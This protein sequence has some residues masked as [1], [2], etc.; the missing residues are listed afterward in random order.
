MKSVRIVSSIS[1]RTRRMTSVIWNS[2]SVTPGRISAQRPVGVASPVLHH[3]TFT[4]WPRPKAGSHC[5]VTENSRMKRMPSAKLGS[6]TPST[7]T[8]W[9][10]C[11]STELRRIAVSTPSGRPIA[12]DRKVATITSSKVAGNRSAISA[13]TSC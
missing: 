4:T 2:D 8:N 10:V 12:I 11:A 1:A 13:E 9:S 5:S 7:E 3:P 6:D